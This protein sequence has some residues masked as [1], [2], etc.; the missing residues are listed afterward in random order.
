MAHDTMITVQ[1]YVGSDVR[2]VQAGGHP[3]ANLRVATTPRRRVR[4][5][6]EWVDGETQWFDVSAWRGLAEHVAESV[7][8][9]DPVLVHGRLSVRR[10]TRQDGTE[11][12]AQEIEALVLG[13]D[14][15]WGVS[16]FTKAV[17]PQA[18]PAA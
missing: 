1:G 10:F 8:R 6:G 4:S 12:I 13:H 16:R 15:T 5:T 11:G 3:V 14:L 17:R 7:H 9:G 2:L 18:A